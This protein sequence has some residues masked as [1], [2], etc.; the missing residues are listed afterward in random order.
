MSNNLESRNKLSPVKETFNL[1]DGIY[2]GIITE[3]FF[4]TNDKILIKIEL[5]D[6]T[7]FLIGTT[8]NK[9]E[10]YPFNKLLSQANIE[11][12][13]D[14]VNLKVKFTVKN[15][16]SSKG[17]TYSDIKRISIAE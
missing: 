15:N 6:K 1:D 7:I 8:I 11:Y 14:L 2:N 9:L 4:Y 12:V 5:S 13:K 17:K 3:L 16:K 10:D